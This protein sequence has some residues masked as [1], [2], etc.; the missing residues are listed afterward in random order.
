[1]S[2]GQ[3]MIEMA[4]KHF[5][6][7]GN[8]QKV[9]VER[10]LSLDD[11]DTTTLVLS[12]E[13]CS[14][15]N[16]FKSL[17][18]E[19]IS[20][21]CEA[22]KSKP[23]C[24]KASLSPKEKNEN[25]GYNNFDD[26][27]DVDYI[28]ED[29]NSSDESENELFNAKSLSKKPRLATCENLGKE[30]TTLDR[31]NDKNETRAEQADERVK[32]RKSINRKLMKERKLKGEEYVTRKGVLVPAKKFI[33][34]TNCCRKKCVDKLPP[35][36]QKIIFDDLLKN[37]TNKDQVLSDRIKLS[38]KKVERKGRSK[39]GIIKDR[40]ITASYFVVFNGQ[41][42]NICKTM[43]QNVSAVTRGKV[44]ILIQKKRASKT[45]FINENLSG[46]H[47]ALNARDEE[48]V[49]VINHINSFPK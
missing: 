18:N 31:G 1:M 23:S 39:T 43:F 48:R 11:V 3:R 2:R 16:V 20:N 10:I 44:D 26:D 32:K 28:P 47:K 12:E 33:P 45:G 25:I 15:G 22:D 21:L 38:D 6:E 42:R 46:H 37:I 9:T 19:D 17:V 14:E 29:N 34:V 35:E 4:R 8:I 27:R 7:T 41:E 49:E 5:D 30:D 36:N 13:T 40:E 24:S